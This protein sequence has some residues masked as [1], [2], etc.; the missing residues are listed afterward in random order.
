MPALHAETPVKSTV[1]KTVALLV[2]VISAA[3]GASWFLAVQV[4]AYRDT[5]RQMDARLASI[6]SFMRTEAVT[7]SQAERYAAAFKWENRAISIVVPTPADY[8]DKPK[9]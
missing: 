1:S 7:Q 9:G 5:L 3:S 6:E 2:S 4:S 8:Q